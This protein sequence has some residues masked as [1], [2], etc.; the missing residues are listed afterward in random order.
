MSLQW[1]RYS[2]DS[3]WGRPHSAHRLIPI[4]ES[5][6]IE[7]SGFFFNTDRAIVSRPSRARHR[8]TRARIDW[9]ED[10]GSHLSLSRASEIR[11]EPFPLIPPIL[12]GIRFNS[13]ASS[14]AKIR[15]ENP[16]QKSGAKIRRTNPAL[17]FKPREWRS[18]RA[19]FDCSISLLER[20]SGRLEDRA[21]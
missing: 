17:Y 13:F 4:F 15:R 1:Y 6:T 3:R 21:A 11:G 16:A 18:L 5:L 20:N 8:H 19:G 7:T 12:L 9:R 10:S 2:D 14:S